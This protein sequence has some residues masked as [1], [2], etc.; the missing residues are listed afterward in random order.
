MPIRIVAEGIDDR[1]DIKPSHHVSAPVTKTWAFLWPHIPGPLRKS[2]HPGSAQNHYGISEKTFKPSKM[3]NK[4][5][6]C[7][8]SLTMLPPERKKKDCSLLSWHWQLHSSEVS[9]PGQGSRVRTQ[10]GETIL[11]I[12]W[13]D[14]SMAFTRFSVKESVT[15]QRS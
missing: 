8:T 12:V 11:D 7:G 4:I 14:R 2:S 13:G 3:I 10:E 6:T 9:P 5:L 1:N 15:H